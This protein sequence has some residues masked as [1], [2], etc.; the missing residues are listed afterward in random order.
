MEHLQVGHPVPHDWNRYLEVLWGLLRRLVRWF[1]RLV[2]GRRVSDTPIPTALEGVVSKIR[3]AQEHSNSLKEEVNAFTNSGDYDTLPERNSDGSEYRLR[4]KFGQ[5]KPDVVRWG[6]MFGDVL[7]NLRSALDHL[8]WQLVLTGGGEPGSTT[9]FPIF[10]DRDKFVSLSRDPVRGVSNK[11]RELIEGVQPFQR[12]R[13][14][15]ALS[16]L[17]VLH[18]LSNWD[19]HRLVHLTFLGPSQGT[20]TPS[21]KGATFEAF[22]VTEDGAVFLIVRPPEPT[23]EMDVKG[24]I[25]FRVA[26]KVGSLDVEVGSLMNELGKEVDGVANL[27][28]REFR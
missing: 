4:I 10:K 7:H 28:L 8:A 11:V 19:K 6:V 12:G 24:E 9:S 15:A 22:D 23:L 16:A 27:F 2:F 1:R 26:V 13:E 25:T 3:R 21:V 14:E 20:V 5:L 17:W 18:E